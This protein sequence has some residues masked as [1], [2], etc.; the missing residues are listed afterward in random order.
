[1]NFSIQPTLEN[2]NILLVPLIEA[3]F[4]RLFEIASDPEVWKMHPNK[5]RYKREVF[6]NFF[7]GAIESKGAFLITNLSELL[8]PLKSVVYFTKSVA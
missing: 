3:D 6:E 5:E 1:M 2:E 8:T 4:E 7:K